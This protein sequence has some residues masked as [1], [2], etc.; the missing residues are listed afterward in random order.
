MTGAQHVNNPVELREN[1]NATGVSKSIDVS[2]MKYYIDSFK[3]G[4]WPHGGCGIGVEQVVSC[5]LGL[6]N[7]HIPSYCSRTPIRLEP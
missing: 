1:I 5:Y 2:S 7:V 4:S 6:N 3:Y